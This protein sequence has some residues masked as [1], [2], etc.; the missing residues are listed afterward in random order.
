MLSWCLR[1]GVFGWLR[2]GVCLGVCVVL[3][4]GFVLYVF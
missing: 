1:V 3:V 4:C 2:S